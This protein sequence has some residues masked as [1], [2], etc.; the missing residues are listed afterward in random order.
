MLIGWTLIEG[1]DIFCI[2]ILAVFF[3]WAMWGGCIYLVYHV[4]LFWHLFLIY[5]LFLSKKEKKVIFWRMT[6]Q[7]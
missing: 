6:H 2:S 4:A 7:V 3:M 5:I 1:E